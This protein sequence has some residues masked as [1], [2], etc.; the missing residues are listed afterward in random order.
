MGRAPTRIDLLRTLPGVVFDDAWTTRITV[1]IEGIPV[2]VRQ[3]R[4][5]PEQDPRR[6][7]ARSKGRA[8]ADGGDRAE[9]E[10]ACDP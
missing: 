7:A 3:S 5:R 6:A 10:K 4:A 8:R 9:T 2:P 1:S